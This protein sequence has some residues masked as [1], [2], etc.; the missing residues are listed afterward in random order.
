[1][2]QTVIPQLQELTNADENTLL[3]VDS[4]IQSYKMTA[5]NLG[6]GLLYIGRPNPTAAKTA[7]YS[8]VVSDA[9]GLLKLDSSA[10][11]FDLQLPNPSSFAKRSLTIKDVAGFLSSNQVNLVRHGNELISGI[12]SDF[13]LESDFGVWDLYCDGT[14]WELL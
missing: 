11:G 6:K 7:N 5:P 2:A 14:N 3:I 9:F 1:M 10:G 8:I 4:G 12:Q 13:A